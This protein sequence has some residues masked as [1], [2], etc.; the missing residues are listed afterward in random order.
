MN[1]LKN[2]TEY[3]WSVFT[4]TSN[5]KVSSPT[6]I[7]YT[8]NLVP[9]SYTFL[10]CLTG[11]T[12]WIPPENGT[13]RITCV[14]KSGDGGD[15]GKSYTKPGING[16]DLYGGNG[17]NGGG[18]GGLSRSV[19]DFT[20]SDKI[21][22]TINGSISSFG[23]YLSST[24]GSGINPGTG[25]GGN[26]FN[27]TGGRGGNGGQG[28]SYYVTPPNIANFTWGEAGKNPIK[29]AMGGKK[30][31][32]GA[33]TCTGGSGGGG[34][35]YTLPSNIK[36][37]DPL[38]TTY[39][40]RDLSGYSGGIGGG[41]YRE[42]SMDSYPSYPIFN[43]KSPI[44]YGGGSGGG[45]NGGIYFDKINGGSGSTGSPGGILIEKAVY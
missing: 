40:K 31:D 37:D 30:P 21:H 1:E 32:T 22:C 36:Y 9:K 28:G 27:T 41:Q 16:K 45:G 24:A 43:S 23:D 14:G 13:Y 7:S 10:T 6:S 5:G 17:G 35:C 4:T 3:H 11:N 12:E 38:Y 19:L 25:K 44:W 42:I 33:Y 2:H 34:A 8:P 39:I 26:D 18:S 29:G 20:T 15:G